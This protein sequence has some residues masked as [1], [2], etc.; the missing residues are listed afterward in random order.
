MIQSGQVRTT[1]SLGNTINTREL[2]VYM[3]ILSFT[4][5]CTIYFDGSFGGASRAT[6][7]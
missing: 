1:D 4:V 6:N 7:P 2:Q 5:V 3:G